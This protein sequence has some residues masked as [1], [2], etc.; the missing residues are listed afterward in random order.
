MYKTTEKF[1]V[2]VKQFISLAITKYGVEALE[3]GD[4]DDIKAMV[5]GLKLLNMSM[6][7]VKEQALLLDGIQADVAVIKNTI[8]Y[9]NS[10]KK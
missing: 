1:V 10:E 3:T 6:E 8:L 4:G 9:T 2:E 7:I 5:T